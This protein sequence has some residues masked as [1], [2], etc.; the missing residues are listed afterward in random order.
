VSRRTRLVCLIGLIF[1]DA[2][3]AITVIDA[4]TR[5]GGEGGVFWSAVGLLAVLGAGLL[6]LIVRVARTPSRR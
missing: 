4:V 6:W 5:S 3:T 2:W 1:A